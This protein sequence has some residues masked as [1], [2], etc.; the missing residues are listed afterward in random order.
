MV[1]MT[2]KDFLQNSKIIKKKMPKNSIF[3]NEIVV[4]VL[5]LCFSVFFFML[6][7]EFL[8]NYGDKM[9]TKNRQ[10]KEE[11]LRKQIERKRRNADS[12]KDSETEGIFLSEN[13]IPE[14][15]PVMEKELNEMA[16][17]ENIGVKRDIKPNKDM[18]FSKQ[19]A[20]DD[21]QMT[22][23]I[24][25]VKEYIS[26]NPINITFKNYPTL[27]KQDKVRTINI[28][29]SRIV[30]TFLKI[31][32]TKMKELEMYNQNH[33]LENF[34][35]IDYRI[36]NRLDADYADYN[37]VWVEEGESRTLLPRNQ[38]VIQEEDKNGTMIYKAYKKKDISGTSRIDMSNLTE[39]DRILV[40]KHKKKNLLDYLESG[41]KFHIRIGRDNKFQFFTLYL[42]TKMSYL[43]NSNRFNIVIKDLVLIDTINNYSLMVNDNAELGYKKPLNLDSNKN[44]NIAS[45]AKPFNIFNENDIPKNYFD[46]KF[47]I[48]VLDDRNYERAVADRQNKHKCFAVVGG[49]SQEI[50]FSN[51][52]YCESYQSDLEQIGIWDGPCQ[53]NDECPFYKGNKNYDN[54]LGGC[55][56]GYCEMPLGVTRIGYKKYTDEP[57]C[58]NC[59]IGTDSRCC[60]QQYLDSKES[61]N[62]IL[63]PD[64]VFIGDCETDNQM[65]KNPTNIETLNEK[66][67][68]NCPSI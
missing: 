19:L 8:E 18:I 56:N 21:E 11:I 51:K 48:K 62:R 61:E 29:T 22:T 3:D 42:D 32:N 41:N 37:K 64:L 66:G 30:N 44:V 12:F 16:G 45:S 9:E 47:K 39:N 67:L 2:Y 28:L 10:I 15:V 26:N 35:L 34:I 38:V 63:S 1:E 54:E 40:K 25:E 23:L 17:I 27:F 6:F 33:L 53:T 49:R 59:P 24:K 13:Q 55:N 5:I 31:F 65:R 7:K 20:I 4:G 14:P 68:E 58:Y 57:Y 36:V 60:Q 43:S 46:D 52:M 50:P